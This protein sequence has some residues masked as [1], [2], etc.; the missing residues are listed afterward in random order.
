METV[1]PPSLIDSAGN[2]P[3]GLKPHLSKPFK[4]VGDFITSGEPMALQQA[5]DKTEVEAPSSRTVRWTFL[6]TT[7]DAIWNAS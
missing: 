2:R 1:F 4:V 6:P 5:I 7:L 3:W